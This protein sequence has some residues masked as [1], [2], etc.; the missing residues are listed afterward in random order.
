MSETGVINPTPWGEAEIRGPVHLHRER[1]VLRAFTALLQEGRI[2]DAG[3]G[4]GSLALGLCKAGYRVD[5]MEQSLEFVQL[6]QHKLSRFGSESRMTV[7]QGSITELPFENG[8]FDGAVC[9]EVLEHIQAEQ[10]GDQAAVQELRRVLRVDAPC[11]VSVPLNPD[12][13]DESD[14]WAGHVKRYEREQLVELFAGN[15]FSVLD[16]HI[17]GFPLGRIYHRVLFAPWIRRTAS[18]DAAS[19]EMRADTRAAS[20]RRLV[21]LVAGAFRLDELFARRPWGRGII[22]STRRSS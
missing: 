2:L 10:G 6:V 14:V 15:G 3:C 19:R 16:T 18:M 21:G 5:A 1:L 12:L 8:S 22:L 7:Q 9:G 13:W 11:V 4:G 20:S 17:W